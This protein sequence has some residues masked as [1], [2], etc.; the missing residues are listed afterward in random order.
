MKRL[1]GSSFEVKFWA[2]FIILGPSNK[3]FLKP[4]F[5]DVQ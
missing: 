1:A 4:V 2:L 5:P 3:P